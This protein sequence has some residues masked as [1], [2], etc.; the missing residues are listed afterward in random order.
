[1]SLCYH[2]GN[3]VLVDELQQIANGQW[4]SGTIYEDNPELLNVLN[5]VGRLIM[6]DAVKT[7][8][9]FTIHLVLALP[10]P[11]AEKE[12]IYPLFIKEPK[13]YIIEIREMHC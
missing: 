13:I 1:M 11:N 10:F 3:P 7:E 4:L 8:S 6:V 2:R 9:A 5:D 12:E